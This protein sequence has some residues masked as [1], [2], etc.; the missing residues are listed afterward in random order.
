MTAKAISLTY[1]Y[2]DGARHASKEQKEI[3]DELADLF[4]VLSNLKKI[5][6]EPG[7]MS[8]AHLVLIER[9]CGNSSAPQIGGSQ[10]SG[11]ALHRCQIALENLIEKLKPATG[12]LAKLKQALKWPLEKADAQKIVDYLNRVKGTLQLALAGHQT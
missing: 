8:S 10:P 11:G 7:G 4:Q 5:T 1:E 3:A 2:Q 12:R 6:A 9:I